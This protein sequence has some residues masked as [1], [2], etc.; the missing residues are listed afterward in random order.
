MQAFI[1]L[2][3]AK[4]SRERVKD[5]RFYDEQAHILAQ[6]QWNEPPPKD[7]ILGELP[8][9]GLNRIRLDTD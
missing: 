2:D 5:N 6:W 9:V 4:R 7:L 8:Y 3:A 1:D